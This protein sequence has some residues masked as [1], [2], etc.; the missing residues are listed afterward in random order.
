MLKSHRTFNEKMIE[1]ARQ[2]KPGCMIIGWLFIIV[3][4]TVIVILFKQFVG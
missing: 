1:L 2:R 3:V 4:V